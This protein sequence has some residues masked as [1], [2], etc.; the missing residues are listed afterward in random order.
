MEQDWKALWASVCAQ[1]KESGD[2]LL[3]AAPAEI[4]RAEALRY[5]A[6]LMGTAVGSYLEP[7]WAT[8]PQLRFGSS[9]I[10][11]DNPDYRYAN[12]KLDGR[13]QYRLRGR[14]NGAKRIAFSTFTNA[15]GTGRPMMSTGAI[16]TDSPEFGLQP[17]GSFDVVLSA[18]STSGSSLM[19]EETTFLM[20]R[21]LLTQ[22]DAQPGEY[23][24]TCL[25]STAERPVPMGP[26]ELHDSLTDTRNFLGGT[27]KTF[28]RWTE[29]FRG[30]PNQILLLP[31]ELDAGAADRQSRYYNGYYDL[32]DDEHGLLIRF[33]PP[34][35]TYWNL[36]ALDHWLESVDTPASRS[37]YNMDTVQMGED[38]SVRAVISVRDAGGPNWIDTAGHLHGGIV[39]R[40]VGCSTGAEDFECTCEV[41][42][43]SDL[44]S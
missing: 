1:L 29:T 14:L 30:K 24:L 23:E 44:E 28:L 13:L 32:P 42:R 6:R 38:G 10:G 21:E 20:V 27:V 18:G 25:S 33:T 43:L 19:T 34:A 12:A 3:D 40:L 35:C 2:L 37:L 9:R 39:M 8:A 7:K 15:F 22:A 36:Q 17:D 41:V 4:D 11:G 5:V 26:K 31:P 16:E